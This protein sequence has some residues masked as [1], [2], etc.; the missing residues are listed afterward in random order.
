MATTASLNF[1]Q[2]LYIA[3]YG[4]PADPLGLSYWATQIDNANGDTSQVVNA[5]GNSAEAQAIYGS[6]GLAA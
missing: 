3:Y 4:R 5:F 1:V 6:Q 2:D